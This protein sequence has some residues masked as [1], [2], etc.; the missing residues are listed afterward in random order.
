MQCVDHAE[1]AGKV[2]L[3]CR[4]IGDNLFGKLLKQTVSG[5]RICTDA[6]MLDEATPTTFAFVQ[7]SPTGD[8]GAFYRNF[9][10]DMLLAERKQPVPAIRSVH[11][12]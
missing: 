7:T 4:K 5:A 10:A 6:L 12:S 8:R 1:K 9:G 11:A 3:I 2:L